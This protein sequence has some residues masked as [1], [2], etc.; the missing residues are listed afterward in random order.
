MTSRSEA[1]SDL[2][3]RWVNDSRVG[4]QLDRTAWGSHRNW[5]RVDRQDLTLWGSVPHC[6][7]KRFFDGFQ[8]GFLLVLRRE[9]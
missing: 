3:V 9:P 4:T 8:K 2:Q 1:L 6:K 5:S 7:E